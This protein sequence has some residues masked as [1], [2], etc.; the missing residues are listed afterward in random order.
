[1][2][3][4]AETVID[5]GV[6]AGGVEPRRAAD[7][8]RRH[9][10]ELGYGFRRILRQRDEFR[11]MQELVPIAT[12]AD[13]FLIAKFF[14][15]DDVRQRGDDGDIGAGA[16]REMKRRFDMRRLHHFGAARIDHDQ[17]GALPQPLFQT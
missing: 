5:R 6:A 9:A 8:L 11:P 15:D 12:L 2:F 14:G 13:E 1:V 7:G 10:G 17:L 4:D 3:G 16:Q